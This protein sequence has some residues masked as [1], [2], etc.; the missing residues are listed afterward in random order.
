MKIIKAD[1]KG[2]TEAVKCLQAGHA[3]IYPTDTA[4]GLAVDAYNETAV[5]KLFK[6]KERSYRQPVHVLV[7]SLAMAKQLARFDSLAERV[8]KKFLP[9]PLTL[10]LPVRTGSRAIGTLSGATGTLGIRMAKHKVAL[11]L[12][13]ALGRPI[14]TTS[15]NIAGGPTPYS[16]EDAFRNFRSEKFQ[17]DLILD[18]GKLPKIKPSTLVA[19]ERGKVNILRK[20]PVAKAAIEKVIK[21]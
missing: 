8:F 4:Y 10:I 21:S 19:L 14:T 5:K 17:P 6:I 7:S 1:K 20:G 16:A 9:G 18:G 15:A 11:A 13:D 3:V 2:I 12:S